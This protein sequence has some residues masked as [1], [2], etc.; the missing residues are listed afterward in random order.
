MDI[1]ISSCSETVPSLAPLHHQSEHIFTTS[2]C[3][4]AWLHPPPVHASQ[5]SDSPVLPLPACP[6]NHA[7]SLGRPFFCCR[8]QSLPYTLPVLK[9]QYPQRLQPCVQHFLQHRK[10]TILSNRRSPP[11]SSRTESEERLSCGK[12][13]A[14]PIA[15]R[16][17]AAF[18]RT[19]PDCPYAAQSHRAAR[20]QPLRLF[21][22][23]HLSVHNRTQIAGIPSPIPLFPIRFT[24][25]PP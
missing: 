7:N 22:N 5:L 17:R 18:T 20:R 21:S 23:R 6:E 12:C 25:V 9:T 2:A 8:S 24:A 16:C 4:Q 11:S 13:D 15:L 3:R 10:I 19:I 14:Q 1:V